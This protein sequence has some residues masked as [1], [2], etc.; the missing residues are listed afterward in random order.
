MPG[1]HHYCSVCERETLHSVAR[2][3]SGDI[4]TEECRDTKHHAR[5]DAEAADVYL[6]VE[7]GRLSVDA[8]DAR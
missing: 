2:N 3:E 5:G 7:R 1:E 8:Q 6:G 4:L